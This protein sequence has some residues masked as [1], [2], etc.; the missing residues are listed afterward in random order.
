MI[1]FILLYI[2]IFNSTSI[3]P[4]TKSINGKKVGR[5]YVKIP[6]VIIIYPVYKGELEHREARQPAQGRGGRAGITAGPLA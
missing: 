6:I 5:K 2:D 3:L 1:L 4:N